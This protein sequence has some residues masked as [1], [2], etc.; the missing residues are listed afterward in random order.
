MLERLILT[1]IGIVAVWLVY[2]GLSSY[3]L[4]RPTGRGVSLD[5]FPLRPDAGGVRR[6][7]RTFIIAARGQPRGVNHGVARVK[8]LASQLA[9]V[10]ELNLPGL[11]PSH[12]PESK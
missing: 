8:K 10:G 4:A 5:R 3:L 7:P 1:L 9:T 12:I 2:R 6:V 11:D